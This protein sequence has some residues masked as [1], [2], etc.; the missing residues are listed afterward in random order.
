ML[1]L[2]FF[3]LT[4]LSHIFCWLLLLFRW[5]W[6]ITIHL[7]FLQTLFCITE[8]NFALV[9]CVL[10]AGL[11][12]NIVR[13]GRFKETT[14]NAKTTSNSNNNGRH[15]YAAAKIVQKIV[16]S[17]LSEVALHPSSLLHR[18]ECSVFVTLLCSVVCLCIFFVFLYLWISFI[19]YFVVKSGISIRSLKDYATYFK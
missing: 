5:Y 9:K 17:D 7:L 6:W 12:P 10:C 15:S 14:N 4:Y 18:W 1:L 3:T 13:L 16:Q 19:S 8:V 11:Y 2:F